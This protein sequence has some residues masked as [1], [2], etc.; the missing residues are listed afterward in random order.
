MLKIKVMPLIVMLLAS[1]LLI[2]VGV[3]YAAYGNATDFTHP[4]STTSTTNQTM[5]PS[6]HT[7]SNQ[8]SANMTMPMS[9]NNTNTNMTMLSNSTQTGQN[10]TTTHATNGTKDAQQISDFVHQAIT[11]FK[12]QKD[13]TLKA[14]F[15]CR[16]QLQQAAPSEIDQIH[17]DCKIQLN[18]INT[19]YQDERNHL[20]DLIKQ[21]RQSVMVFL[22]DARGHTV[23]TTTMNNAL[24]N[25]S[26]MMHMGMSSGGMTNHVPGF[27][28]TMNNTNCLNSTS[29][30]SGIC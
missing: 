18:S 26:S 8:T 16:D 27:T 6:N 23:D 19:K 17:S 9:S 30:H 21:Y 13:E 7:M 24:V 22:M 10:K 25:L 20:H 5:T 2:P 15:S 1:T 29:G 3:S 4:S 12:T 11:H 28:S 14:I